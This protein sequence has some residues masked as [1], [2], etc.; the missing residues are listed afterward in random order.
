MFTGI[1]TD[2]GEILAVTPLASGVRFRIGT[3]YDPAGIDMGA[4]I[5][6][7]GVCLTVVERGLDGNRAYFD[8]EASTETLKVSTAGDW[9]RTTR[10]NLER[11]LKLGDE[12]GGHM[13]TGHVDG[14]AEILE[15]RNEGDMAVFVVRVPEAYAR[16]IAAKGSVALDGT[17]LTVNA[18][19]G[20]TFRVML[21][22]HSL[23]VTTWGNRRAGDRINLE[24]DLMARYAARLA[25]FP[26]LG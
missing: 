8:A 3:S 15:R 21:I 6:C 13:V 5:A 23:A 26:A 19:D 10:L 12:M 18:V 9:A 2:I 16:F 22:P 11:S 20:D 14:V 7:S 25:A 24:V 4:S 1:V 17:S